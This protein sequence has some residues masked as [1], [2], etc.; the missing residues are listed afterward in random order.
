MARLL[1]YCDA[2]QQD[3][4]IPYQCR[5]SAEVVGCCARRASGSGSLAR[6]TTTSSRVLLPS[7]A[8]S[9]QH[10]QAGSIK[11]SW[12]RTHLTLIAVAAS[13]R[14]CLRRST[15]LFL[16]HGICVKY[17]TL[18][19]LSEAASMQYIASRTTIPVPKVY[20]AFERKGITYIV[21]SRIPGSPIGHKWEQRPEA[22]KARLLKQLE[23]YVEE[24]RLLEPS[25]PG[26]IED[27]DGDKLYDTRLSGR[28]GGFGPF[29]S[30]Q[31]FH[32]FLRDG[33]GSAPGQ[34][35]EVNELVEKHDHYRFTT[36]FTHGDLNSMNIH[37]KGDDIVGVHDWEAAG[38]FPEYWE[39]TSAK[40]VNPY[41]GFWEAEVGKF[42]DEYPEAAHMEQLRQKYF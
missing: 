19:Y 15:V 13:E 18:R 31:N 39:Y 4:T 20:C 14:F 42:L 21:M 12:L 25:H 2:P 17:G 36:R 7:S 35:P 38:W 34:I 40:N 6:T 37:V 30:I 23:A 24:M 3:L 33:I 9:K 8:M 32:A 5:W 26:M 41:N 29:T 28:P 1:K 27:V 16:P 10:V 22:S 11:A